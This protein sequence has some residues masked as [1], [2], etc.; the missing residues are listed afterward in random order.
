MRQIAIKGPVLFLMGPLG[1]FFARFANDL[2]SQGVPIIKVMFPLYEF[3]FKKQECLPYRGSM[4]AYPEFLQQVLLENGIRHVFMYGDFIDPHRL[5]IDVINIINGRPEREFDID[6]W[7]FELGYIR[8]NFITLERERVNARS[9]LNQPAN[10]YD[11]LPQVNSIRTNYEKPGSRWRKVWKFPTFIQH[12]LTDY[13]IIHGPHKLQPKPSYLLYQVRGLLRKYL[14]HFTENK[15]RSQILDGH[16]YFLVPLQVSSDSQVSL[17]SQYSGMEPFIEELIVSFAKN[18]LSGNR[19][20]FKHHPRDRGYNH[21][22]N[23]IK[24]TARQNGVENMILYFHDGSLGPILKQAK[25]VI[26]INSTVGLQAL[27]HGIPTKVMGKTYYNLAG[28]TDQQD[29]AKFWKNPTSSNQDLFYKFYDHLLTT[30]QL[31]GNFD[32]YFNFRS[33]FLVDHKCSIET[34]ARRPSVLEIGQRFMTLGQCF[35]LYYLQLAALLFGQQNLAKRQLVRSAQLGLQA[36]GVNV[37]MERRASALP[38]RQIHIANHGHPLDVLLVQG[39]F[40]DCS[41]TTAARHL[42]WILPFLEQSAANYGHTNLDHLNSTSR[43]IGFHKILKMLQ[44]R[45]RIFLFPSGSLVTPITQRV[46]PSLYVLSRRT[47][48]AIVPWFCSY[49]GFPATEKQLSYRP[50]ALIVHRIL[51]PQAT[52]LCKEGHPID[53]RTFINRQALSEHIINLYNDFE[54]NQLNLES[55]RTLGF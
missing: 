7:V 19:L 22:G 6:T 5:A 45:G 4:E 48:A 21:Y 13:P 11:S 29:L 50:L 35:G 54:K 16:P 23:F 24:M 32:S 37:L 12:A 28:I 26:T 3:G 17:G 2:K 1:T 36:L 52:I 47:G 42:K 10:F 9:S 25:A 33:N 41:L 14:Y 8:P 18:H 38:Y 30:T 44:Q 27:Y 34:I 55:L 49:R 51:G 40:R 46:S 15:V 43:R 53:S 31:E 20:I 39:Y